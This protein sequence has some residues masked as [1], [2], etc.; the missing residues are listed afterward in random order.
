MVSTAILCFCWKALAHFLVFA[1][2]VKEAGAVPNHGSQRFLGHSYWNTRYPSLGYSEWNG[3]WNNFYSRRVWYNR[4]E[5]SKQYCTRCKCDTMEIQCPKNL[6]GELKVQNKVIKIIR[7]GQLSKSLT[8]VKFFGTQL[9]YIEEEAFHNLTQMEDLN[10]ANNDLHE[11]PDLSTN[12]ALKELILIDNQIDWIPE[13][14]FDLP[15]LKYIALSMNKL[16]ALPGTAFVNCKSMQYLSADFNEIKEIT[17]PNLKPLFGN[18]SQLLHLNLSNNHISRISPEALQHLSHLKILELHDNAMEYIGAKVFYKIPQ[19]LHLDLVGNKLETIAAEGYSPAFQDLPKLK[20][21][22]LMA[23]D[24]KTRHVMYNSFVGL[25]S[26][27]DLWLNNNNLV[28]FPHP[29]L[30]YEK[31]PALNFLHVENNQIESLTSYGKGD[32]P[33]ELENLHGDL[34]SKHKPFEKTRNLVK[35]FVHSNKIRAIDEE[36]LWL[37]D[38]LQEIFFSYNNL[39]NSSVHPLAFRNLTRLSVLHLDGNAFYYVP[40]ALQRKSRIPAVTSLD[41]QGNVIT[42][43][44]KETFSELDKLK[45]LYMQSNKIVTIENGAFNENIQHIDL[46]DNRFTFKHGNQF[47]N[48]SNL[49]QLYLRKNKI[50]IIP[51]TAFH[52]MTSL[53][54]LDL[55]KNKIGR[56]LKILFR[57]IAGV[58]YLNLDYNEIAY[59]ED[60]TFE[61]F[62]KFD[63]LKLQ[64]N[65]LTYLPTGGDFSNME[66]NDVDFSN[67]RIT[68]I[69]NGTFFNVNCITGFCATNGRGTIWRFHDNE[70]VSIQSGAF[71]KFNGPTCTL[72][73]T[74]GNPNK[75]LLKSI[76]SR[77]FEDVRTCHIDLRFMKLEKI[78]SE[79][80]KDVTVKNDIEINN[81][82]IHTIEQNAFLRITTRHLKLENNFLNAITVKM[83]GDSASFIQGELNLAYNKIRG[84]H[85]ESLKGVK[86]TQKIVLRNN[87]L[88]IFPY[89][90]L[91]SQNPYYLEMQHN[92][93]LSIPNGWLDSFSNLRELYLQSNSI[94]TLNANVFSK[95]GNLRALELH[96]NK[97]NGIEPAAFN[98]LTKLDRLYLH[99]NAIQFVPTFPELKFLRFLWL[100]DN[101]IEN[102][103]K[104]CFNN[105]PNLEKLYLGG[106]NQLACDC[107]VYS[108]IVHVINSVVS[109][110]PPVCRTPSQVQQVTFF[111]GGTYANVYPQRFLCN[112]V[113]VS[114]SAL[115]DYQL[116]VT[117]DRPQELHVFINVTENATRISTWD[118][119]KVK[120]V[121]YTVTCLS[122]DAATLSNTSSNESLLFTQKDGVQAGTDYTCHVTMTVTAHNGT[123]LDGG[124]LGSIWTRTTPKSEK[125]SVTTIEGKAPLVN[126]TAN[127]TNYFLDS[128]FYDFRAAD[129]DFV[130]VPSTYKE[131]YHNP[132]HIASPYGSWLAVSSTPTASSFSDWFR[133]ESQRN[134]HYEGKLELKKQL[135]TDKNG[136]SVFRLY[137]EKFFPVDGRGF[138]AEGQRD[139]Y[140]NALRNYGFTTAIRTSF[141]FSG[142]ENIAVAGGEELWVFIAGHLVLE[143]FHDPLNKTIPC[144]TVNLDPVLKGEG[145]IFSQHGFIANG[146]CQE[147][148]NLSLQALNLTLRVGE[149]YRLDI[150]MAERF[151]KD[152]VLFLQTSGV[153]FVRQWDKNTLPLDYISEISEDTH[154]GS[155]VQELTVSDAFS[156]GPYRV[157]ILTGN[158]QRRFEIKDEGYSSPSPPSTV[159]PPSFL[160]NGETIYLCPNATANATVR[161]ISTSTPGIESFTMSSPSAKLILK[162]PL[163]YE[164]TTSYTLT[165]RITDTGKVNQPSG[166]ITIKIFILDYNDHCPVLPD[167]EYALTPIPPLQKAP[168]FVA[169]A[170]DG[171]SGF[172]AK[173]TF[174]SQVFQKIPIITAKRY[175]VKNGSDFVW[176][177]KT[178]EW[179]YHY[180][181]F[182]VDGGTPKRGDRIPLAITF[183]A[184]CQ[185]TGEIVVNETSGEVFFRAPGMT[186][187]EYPR[188]STVKPKCQRC[189]TGYYCVGDGTEKKCGVTSPTEFSFGGAPNCSACPR[190]WLCHN[191]TALPCPANTHVTCNSTWCPEKCFPCEPGTVCR[192]GRQYEC[193]VGTYS[194]GTGYPCKICPPGSYNNATKAETCHC[195]RS[196]YSSTYMKTSCRACPPNEY[197]DQGKF[198]KCSMCRTCSSTVACPC[199]KGPCFPSVDCVNI[200]NGLFECGPCPE[201]FQGDGKS[202]I[203]INECVLAK[204]CYESSQCVNLSPGYRCGGCPNGY[205]G[206]APSGVGLEHAQKYKQT[207]EEID[208]CSDGI[209]T[210]DPNSNCINTPGSFKCSPCNPGFIGD[211]YFG[212]YPG[213]LCTNGSHT[214]QENAQCISRGPGK[215]KCTCRD[216]F[217]GDGEECEQDPDLDAIPVKG[218]SCTLHVCRK[219][220][221]PSVPNTGQEDNDGD[222]DGDAC[223]DDDDNDLIPDKKDNCIFVK[224]LDQEDTDKDGV[225]NACDNCV[226]VHN[227]LQIDTDGDGQGDECDNDKDGDGI[228]NTVDKCAKLNA[229]GDQVDDDGD[230][231]GNLCDNCP[232]NS[233]RLQSDVNKN[234]YGDQCDGQGKDKDGDGVLDEFDNCPDLPNGEQA[235]ADGDN[236]GDACDEDQDND[237]IANILDNCRLI[238]NSRQEHQKLAYDVE[239]NPVGD[240]CVNDFD[241]DGVP[242]DDDMC[243]HVTHI[244]KTSF[245]NYFTVDLYP[246]HGEPSPEWRV[247]KMGVDVEHLSNTNRPGMLIGATRYGPVDYS[248]TIYV[249]DSQGSD[250]LGVVFGYQSNLKFYVVMWRREN[251][252][253]G[254]ADYNAGIKG[255]QLKVVNSATGPG[256][257]L[258][259]AL[260]HAGDTQ[261]QVT[262]LWDDPSMKGWRHQTPYGFH[263]THRPS[264]GLIRV[265]IKQGEKVLTDSGNIYNTLLTGGRLGMIVYG[266]HDVIWSRLEARCF[267]RVNQALM[268]D[269]LDDHVT[270]ASIHDLALTGSFTISVWVQMAADYPLTVM[271]IVCSDDETLCLYLNNRRIHGNLGKSTV[272]GSQV[273]EPEKWHHVVFRFDAQRHEIEVFVNGLSVGKKV[274]T[275]PYVWSSTVKLVVGRDKMHFLNGTIDDLTLWGVRVPGS[276]I[277]DYMKLAGLTW[278]IHKGLVRAHFNM[279]D[280][281]GS[282]ILDQAGNGFHGSLV[283]SPVFVPSNIDKNRFVLSYPKNRRK[284]SQ[285]NPVMSAWA[286]RHS[287]L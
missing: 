202:C 106:R 44:L 81:N 164:H 120:S 231:I 285:R 253:Y 55:G 15:N 69:S 113:N 215:Y 173:I 40:S 228:L 85:D 90:A 185:E 180:Y 142:Q 57:D 114:A 141:N 174:K 200:G 278:P 24:P 203:D 155:I 35:L 132:K 18:D 245:L 3:F 246:G 82:K 149:W 38:K 214:C 30:S 196:G 265:R 89:R 270:L 250:Y 187:S 171:D 186:G 20:C 259:K 77:A 66:I 158:E 286:G 280:T 205:R 188:N 53:S 138:G 150:F 75:Y 248:G 189:S 216:G 230:G 169:V 147:S 151:T 276:E 244:S 262:L 52:G 128:T 6:A 135:E 34:R 76:G 4:S 27:E 283:G 130:G 43:I 229:T 279:E 254:K 31:R 83:F 237:G 210:C 168:F 140:T 56:I 199:M 194:D 184:T 148:G 129:G 275:A 144:A 177:N 95:L 226:N 242:D 79:T 256:S 241:A 266:Q 41:L 277:V 163:D 274:D 110:W 98:G 118:A 176:S 281:S 131:L 97:I 267:D 206:N 227:T 260:W 125:A 204:P 33:P 240:A 54:H 160:L 234:G 87:K 2:L 251:I 12:T 101:Q 60:G 157:E 111:P 117:W 112:P 218:L 99:E 209:D 191:G 92:E 11:F 146:K 145:E 84:L 71:K 8:K 269:G 162:S 287:E 183:N 182:A 32:F 195:C 193:L 233:N 133:S 16:K 80:F 243:P 208:E 247:A 156:L 258:A 46:S 123:Y 232:K 96:R 153:N 236:K 21:L 42:Y 47:T 255:L 282:V 93:I 61:K 29:S 136:N 235:D 63:R 213:D 124:S 78:A 116:L 223:D 139:G 170:T 103:G 179:S 143:V 86:V 36:D 207:C 1:I 88:V 19:L 181:I 261:N 13:K 72:Q 59:I 9:R 64:H 159:S 225:G 37:L 45:S 161:P 284:R 127:K 134:L 201:G 94:T 263:I 102:L 109:N 100:A 257:S 197:A 172:N 68:T 224:N 211:G 74:W 219:D 252:N 152:S 272:I 221:C 26:L 220:N 137:N 10:L 70:I 222:T 178:A 217:A 105:L 23:Q 239:V 17:Y 48:L 49:N 238:S 7:N 67:N 108:S 62:K 58:T 107:N 273:I 65:Q 212:C 14:W 122:K 268:F 198:P 91:Q 5:T 50:R 167:V 264:I 28:N 73:F 104:E 190:G 271:P 115:G 22:V 121:I 249:K 175:A 166:N 165:L 119:V 126:T 192:E 39:M 51:D 25:P 154:V